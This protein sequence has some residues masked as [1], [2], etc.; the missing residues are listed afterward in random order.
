M[1]DASVTAI[2]TDIEGTT[3]D[4]DFVHNTLFPYARSRL[5]GFLRD[6]AERPEVEAELKATA[7]LAGQP[8][9][10]LNALTDTLITWIDEDRK[11]TPLKNLQGLVWRQGY[12]DGDFK[13]H[14]YPDAAAAL[15]QWHEKGLAL[16]VYS[17]GSVEAQKL[18]FG[19]SDQGD[20]APLFTGYFDTTTGPKREAESY[21][22]IQQAIGQ[23]AASILFLSDILAELD[24]ARE[25]GLKTI[26]LVRKPDVV[27]DEHPW[28]RDFSAL[29][30]IISD[31]ASSEESP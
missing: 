9:D 20:L 15:R 10:D 21:R 28:V 14:A 31:K 3:T 24:A 12:E 5:P 29:S 1:I 30:S 23:P 26:Q 17:S 25:A 11:A 2:V 22:L 8:A 19:Y 27:T 13:G 6:H 18:L 7:E 16:Y 4:I